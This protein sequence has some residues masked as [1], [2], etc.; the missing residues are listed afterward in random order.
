LRA[1]L[2]CGIYKA[3]HG[4]ESSGY[5]TICHVQQARGERIYPK[6]SNVAV[7][8]YSREM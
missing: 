2:D 5:D 1:M 7:S 6:P 3:K 8:D 4:R